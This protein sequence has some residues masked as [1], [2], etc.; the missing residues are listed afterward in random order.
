MNIGR[1]KSVLKGKAG[2]RLR[3]ISEY[4]GVVKLIVGQSIGKSSAFGDGT[5]LVKRLEGASIL[6]S[7]YNGN[8]ISK[9]WVVCNSETEA[10]RIS[11]KIKTEF[12]V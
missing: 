6:T 3:K 5:I 12:P 10:V 2:I 4:L 7:V 1:H 11:D 9:V 8:G